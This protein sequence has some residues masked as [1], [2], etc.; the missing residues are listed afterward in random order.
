MVADISLNDIST[1]ADWSAITSAE[2]TNL[3]E[4]ISVGH[5]NGGFAG[6]FDGQMHKIAR[7]R[8]LF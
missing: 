5:N 4:W 7:C 8:G 6:T 3:T 1:V 2:A